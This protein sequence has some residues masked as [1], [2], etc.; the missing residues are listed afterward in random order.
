MCACGRD[1]PEHDGIASPIASDR[2]RVRYFTVY[3]ATRPQGGDGT[4]P[5]GAAHLALERP[6]RSV[7]VAA[8]QAIVMM[9]AP[10][11]PLASGHSPKHSSPNTAAMTRRV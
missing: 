4:R 2:R 5:V 9:V 6:G 10:M 8:R 11:N 1:K 7:I 3:G